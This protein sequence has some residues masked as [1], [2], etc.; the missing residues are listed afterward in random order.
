MELYAWHKNSG[1]LARIYSLTFAN[2]AG[3]VRVV[4]GRV[5]GWVMALSW[6]TP[7]YHVPMVTKVNVICSHVEIRSKKYLC[8]DVNWLLK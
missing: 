6:S 5:S 1:A 2:D 8:S 4:W 7:P 3:D